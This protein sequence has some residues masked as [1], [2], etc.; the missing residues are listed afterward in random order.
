MQDALC[1]TFDD[2]GGHDYFANSDERFEFYHTREEKI[3]FDLDLFNKITK[4]GLSKKSLNIILAGT[5]V[6]KSLFMCHC[7]AANIN[8]GAN[9]LYITMEMAEERIA[10]RI[11]ANLLDVELADLRS[12]SKS[13]YDE[14][15]RLKSDRL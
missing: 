8:N 12:L 11:D 6:G 13:D 1:I 14:K 10:E 5:G 7:A 2:S 4:G 3:K 9:V 15:I